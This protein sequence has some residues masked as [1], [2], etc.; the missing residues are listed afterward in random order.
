M[1]TSMML[2]DLLNLCQNDIERAKIRFCIHNE[3]ESQLDVYLR[4]SEGVNHHALFHR[5]KK[6]R[7]FNVGD[8][9]ICLVKL[10]KNSWLL[11]TIKEV[12]KEY[13]LT[14]ATNYEGVELE[15]YKELF[16]RLIVKY[17]KNHTRPTCLLVKVLDKLEVEQILPSIFRKADR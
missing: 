14:N 6:Q 12:T 4:D 2:N 13:G 10:S 16:G 8:I 17:D 7:F 1:T 3:K 11:T 9:A 15:T 5:A